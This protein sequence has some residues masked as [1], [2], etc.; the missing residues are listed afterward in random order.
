MSG[1]FGDPQDHSHFHKL[2]KFVFQDE[3]VFQNCKQS[4]RPGSCQS[5]LVRSHLIQNETNM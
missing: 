1:V 4:M 2:L 3:A 5:N